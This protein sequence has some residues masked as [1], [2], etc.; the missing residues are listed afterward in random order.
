MRN[1]F[2]KESYKPVPSGDG[3]KLSLRAQSNGTNYQGY[4]FSFTEPWLGGY[5]PTSLSVSIFHT[6]NSF[7]WRQKDDPLRQVFFN[8]GATVSV[9]KRLKWP[10][11]FFNINY[12]FS[13]QQYRM[14]NMDGGFY[15][16]PTG[17]QGISY[18][19]SMQVTLTRSS[20]SEPIYPTSGSK[21]S[22]FR[23]GFVTNLTKPCCNLYS[24]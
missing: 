19:P 16:F 18:N 20:V 14:Q 24:L 7:D 13:F 22:L 17:F 8:T 21:L 6:V 9:G 12:Q 23:Y 3:Q 10:D 1:I 2:D 15:G 11:D 4:T 5:K